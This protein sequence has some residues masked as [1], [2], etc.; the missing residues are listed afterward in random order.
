MAEDREIQPWPDP[1]PDRCPVSFLGRS[2]PSGMEVRV[3]SIPGHCELAYEP[4]E[5]A[6]SLVVV[7]AGEIEL[8]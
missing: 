1:D 7:E 4:A 8:E 2:A 5:W 6:G 3:V